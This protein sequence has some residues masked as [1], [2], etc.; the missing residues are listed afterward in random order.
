MDHSL[1]WAERKANRNK[2][3]LAFVLGFRQSAAEIQKGLEP[4]ALA[5]VM[6]GPLADPNAVA[7]SLYPFLDGIIEPQ[8]AEDGAGEAD[9]EKEG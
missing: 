2:Q 9:E 5:R 1:N 4:N 8:N 7:K 3:M 6:A